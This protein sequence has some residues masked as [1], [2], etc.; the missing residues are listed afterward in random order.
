[1]ELPIISTHINFSRHQFYCFTIVPLFV[2]D[3]SY[4]LE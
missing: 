3:K 4:G 2:L 1:M